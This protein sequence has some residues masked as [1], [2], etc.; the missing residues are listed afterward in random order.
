[1][2]TGQWSQTRSGLEQVGSGTEA[3]TILLGLLRR[4]R[5]VS[6]AEHVGLQ[7]VLSLSLAFLRASEAAEACCF[8]LLTFFKI[9][10]LKI[11]Y[12]IWRDQKLACL[13]VLLQAVEPFFRFNLR[14]SVAVQY[15]VLELRPD[16]IPEVK[17]N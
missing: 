13:H 14:T 5:R 4:S 11:I 7:G 2:V 16:P 8:Y 17:T 6:R 1:M 10:I 15:R 3:K 12:P 9:D